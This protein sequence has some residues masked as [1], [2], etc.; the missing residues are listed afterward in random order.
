MMKMGIKDDF[1]DFGLNNSKNE[2]A[3]FWNGD[4]CGGDRVAFHS[5]VLVTCGMCV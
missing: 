2:I 3:I 5:L 4:D 1:K